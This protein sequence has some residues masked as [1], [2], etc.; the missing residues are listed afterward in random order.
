[1]K[2]KIKWKLSNIKI[3][4]KKSNKQEIEIKN[5][6]NLYDMRDEVI[7]FYKD[8]STIIFNTVYDTRHGKGLKILTPKQMH[9]RL[10]IALV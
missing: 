10:P 1:M 2:K 6:T 4:V 8:Y 3:G 7:K 5:I 9:Q